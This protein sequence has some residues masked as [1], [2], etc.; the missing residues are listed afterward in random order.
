MS[1]YTPFFV[2]FAQNA[3]LY[4]PALGFFGQIVTSN[5]GRAEGT[6]SV[7]ES[8]MPIVNFARLYALHVGLDERNTLERLRRLLDKTVLSASSH[9]ETVSAYDCL[10]ELRLR[11]QARAAI[12]GG[13]PDNQLN[14][15]HLTE[16]ET[17]MVRKSL[18]QLSLMMKRLS[19]DFLGH[20]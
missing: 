14:P 13:Q 8:L 16:V 4:K 18:A 3:L 2:H 20:S 6:F 11:H 10:M 12:R 17:A 9:A 5:E 7:K 19:F 15:R 1:E